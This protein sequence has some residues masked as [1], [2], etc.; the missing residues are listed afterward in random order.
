MLAGKGN[1]QETNYLRGSPILRHTHVH[2]EDGASVPASEWGDSGHTLFPTIMEVWAF[3]GCTQE[4]RTVETPTSLFSNDGS[5]QGCPKRKVVSSKTL[6]SASMI[7]G[8]RHL[9]SLF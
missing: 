1:R 3:V 7:V 9:I 5:G 4:V 8:E 2:S 6:L